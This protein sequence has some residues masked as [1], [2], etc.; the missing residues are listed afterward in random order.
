MSVPIVTLL[1]IGAVPTELITSHYQAIAQVVITMWLLKVKQTTI[2][3]PVVT[4]NPV[5]SPITGRQ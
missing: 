5:T 4:V 2:Y 3:R 1:I